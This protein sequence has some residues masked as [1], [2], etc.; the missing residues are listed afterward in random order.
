[1]LSHGNAPDIGVELFVLSASKHK[2]P[3]MDMNSIA[4]QAQLALLLRDQPPGTTAG[5]T[6][7]SVACWNGYKVD[8]IHLCDEKPGRLGEEFHI[9][10]HCC[11]DA[12]DHL[13][14]WF[15]EPRST[16]RPELLAWLKETRSS[17]VDS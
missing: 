5:A 17:D 7:Q 11:D 2:E 16:H 6:D 12:H 10:E 9:D 8:G 3:P 14:A 4:I 1:L 13:E 15:A